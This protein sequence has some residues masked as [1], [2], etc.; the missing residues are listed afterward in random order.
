MYECDYYCKKCKQGWYQWFK[1]RRWF[2]DI[3]GAF[4][5]AEN[6]PKCGKSIVP[7]R[8]EF[9]DTSCVP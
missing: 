2:L 1:K 9:V 6:C 4:A 3:R 5:Y 7:Y 8:C